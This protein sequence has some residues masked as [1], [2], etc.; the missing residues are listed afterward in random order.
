MEAAS[1][2]PRDPVMIMSTFSARANVST[3]AATPCAPSCAKA[4]GAR[5]TKRYRIP[6]VRGAVH[7]NNQEGGRQQRCGGQAA[8]PRQLHGGELGELGVPHAL[9]QPVQTALR[10]RRLHRAPHLLR[11]CVRAAAAAGWP[12]RGWM[13]DDRQ[14]RCRVIGTQVRS[15]GARRTD[16]AAP[17]A[18]RAHRQSSRQSVRAEPKPSTR[19]PRAAGAAL[20]TRSEEKA[21]ASP[22]LSLPPP[23]N[24]AQQIIII[25]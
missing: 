3:A 10:E 17:A 21:A 5:H 22:L 16:H 18:A 15:A 24:T 6:Q 2:R 7:H 9:Q 13:A 1:L 12:P 8:A 25:P 23:G 11:Q 19:N 4:A 20:R 14:C